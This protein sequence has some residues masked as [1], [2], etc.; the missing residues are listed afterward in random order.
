MPVPTFVLFFG[1]ELTLLA[2]L[3]AIGAKAPVRI[4][5]VPRGSPMRPG[6]YTIIEDVIAVDTGK[7]K[8]YREAL[9]ARYE[10]SPRF[11]RMLRQL[12]WFWAIP[13]VIVGGGAIA[14]VWIQDIEQTVS[15]GLGWGLPPA[16]AVIWVFLTILYA[17][18]CLRMEKVAWVNDPKA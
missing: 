8:A 5:S 9:N 18:R 17:R 11:R 3:D 4:S 13:A 10:I 2:F 16:W 7:G 1:T 6:I 12:N 14:I 15:Y